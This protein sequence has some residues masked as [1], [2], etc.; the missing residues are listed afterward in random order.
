FCLSLAIIFSLTNNIS[1]QND[2][3]KRLTQEVALMKKEKTND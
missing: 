3:V 1:L 2:K